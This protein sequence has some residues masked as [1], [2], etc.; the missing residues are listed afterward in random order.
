MLL[1]VCELGYPER[2]Q[3]MYFASARIKN[4]RRIIAVVVYIYRTGGMRRFYPCLPLELEAI[5]VCPGESFGESTEDTHM[6]MCVDGVGEA[7]KRLGSP[8]NR[9]VLVYHIVSI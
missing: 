7:G 9:M 5:F 2:W 1:C 8:V 6:Y 4:H 3:E